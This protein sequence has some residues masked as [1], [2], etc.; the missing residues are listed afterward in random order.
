MVDVLF[1]YGMSRPSYHVVRLV[2]TQVLSLILIGAITLVDIA[3]CEGVFAHFGWQRIE[4]YHGAMWGLFIPLVAVAIG[5]HLY[6]TRNPALWNPRYRLTTFSPRAFVELLLFTVSTILRA[7]LGHIDVLYYWIQGKPIP[8]V[9]PWLNKT[10]I[11][12]VA[13]WL[14]FA[15]V[16]RDA[17]FR[18]VMLAE[19]VNAFLFWIALKVGGD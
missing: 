5:I 11:G 7:Y 9:L 16:T 18:S 19:L 4:V 15:E 13:R 14:G 6:V 3:L 2:S 10:P 1:F 12:D 17:L 8:D